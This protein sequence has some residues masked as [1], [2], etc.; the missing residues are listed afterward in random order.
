[1]NTQRTTHVRRLAAT[2]ALATALG[3]A[4]CGGG[5]DSSSPVALVPGTQV[6]QSATSSVAGVIAF[7][8]ELIAGTSE[9]TDPIAVGDAVLFTSETDDPTPIQ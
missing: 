4:G 5:G 7:L 2:A 6:P 9:T 8:M 1:M 3:L